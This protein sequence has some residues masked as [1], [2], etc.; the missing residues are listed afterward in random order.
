ML[1][2][3]SGARSRMRRCSS[4]LFACAFLPLPGGV[5][6]QAFQ[7]ANPEILRSYFAA[8]DQDGNGWISFRESHDS[9][10]LDRVGYARLDTDRDGRVVLEEFS[11]HLAQLADRVG[12]LPLPRVAQDQARDVPRK[13]TLILAA[14]D[15]GGDGALEEAELSKLLEDY[16]RAR[17]GALILLDRLDQDGDRRLR[18]SE[19][20]LLARLLASLHVI[21]AEDSR[22]ASPPRSVDELFGAVIPRSKGLDALPEPALIVGP[23]SHFRRLDLDGDGGIELRDLLELMRPRSAAISLAALFAALDGN[24]DGLVDQGELS[25]A[26]GM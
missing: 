2:G 23:V 18:G 12:S 9:L 5:R 7:D 3:L 17:P 10:E 20:E 22:P 26:L 14:Y 16:R 15:R 11:V 21:D 4:W 13:P 24:E 25:R 19:I 1:E 6:S 8:C